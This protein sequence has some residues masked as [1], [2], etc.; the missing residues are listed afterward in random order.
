MRSYQNHLYSGHNKLER[1][2]D[3]KDPYLLRVVYNLILLLF[4]HHPKSLHLLLLKENYCK[5][6]E[7]KRESCNI[8]LKRGILSNLS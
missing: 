6:G 5:K 7:N 1:K 2:K 3:L 4:N 8:L